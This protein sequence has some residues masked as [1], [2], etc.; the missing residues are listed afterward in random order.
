ML[1]TRVTSGIVL[2]IIISAVLIFGGPL[3]ACFCAFISVVGLYEY[4]RAIGFLP[5]GKKIVRISVAA[6]MGALV[7]FALMLFGNGNALYLLFMIILVTIVMLGIYVFSFPKYKAS[8]IVCAI[9]GYIYVPVMICFIFMTRQKQDGQ[10][11]VWLIFIASWVCDTFAYFTGML[12]GKHKLAPILS[13]KKS[14]EGAVGGV[15]FAAA[16]GG[17]YGYFVRDYLLQDFPVI[18][19][20]IVICAV[21][22][23]VSQVGDLAASAIKRNNDIKDYGNLIPGHGGILDRF[24]SVIF[25]AP[26]IYFIVSFFTM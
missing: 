24:D 10:F 1:K 13:P 16:A 3:L 19:A 8:E 22:A 21:G 11:L 15:V 12:F 17:L 20:F 26:M 25:T 6:Y 7:L 4:Y 18:P 9:F 2:V 23:C 5:E 14:I